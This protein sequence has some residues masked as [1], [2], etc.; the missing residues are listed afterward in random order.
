MEVDGQ[1][2]PDLTTFLRVVNS[3]TSRKDSCVIKF[4]ELSGA[5]RVTSMK[6]EREHWGTSEIRADEQQEW[7]RID[8][9]SGS[10]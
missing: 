5:T 9:S 1:P 2:T 3:L 10:A 8:H 4:R 6:L 7:T